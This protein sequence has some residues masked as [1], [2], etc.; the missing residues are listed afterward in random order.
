[1]SGYRLDTI[2]CNLREF[3]RIVGLTLEDWE[4]SLNS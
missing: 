4:N 1:M 3:R 2:V